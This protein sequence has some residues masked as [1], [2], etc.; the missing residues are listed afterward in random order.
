V[1]ASEILYVIGQR[2]I[3]QLIAPYRCGD[4][5]ILHASQAVDLPEKPPRCPF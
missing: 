1:S 4:V 5:S 2:V 3:G